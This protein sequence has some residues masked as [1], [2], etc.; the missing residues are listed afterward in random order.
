MITHDLEEEDAPPWETACMSDVRRLRPD[1]LLL[2]GGRSREPSESELIWCCCSTIE[3][4]GSKGGS[5][6]RSPAAC[7]PQQHS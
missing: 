5:N 6:R 1:V 2:R 4:E 3:A 7:R